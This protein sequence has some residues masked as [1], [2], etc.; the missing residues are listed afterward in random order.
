MFVV[1]LWYQMYDRGFDPTGSDKR[2]NENFSCALCASVSEFTLNSFQGGSK[3]VALLK[4]P[5]FDT[6]T[7]CSL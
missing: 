4:H 2:T 6:T 7:Q 3:E 5:T 1:R